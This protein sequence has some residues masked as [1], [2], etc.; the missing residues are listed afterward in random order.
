MNKTLHGPGLLIK[1]SGINIVA[2]NALPLS[3]AGSSIIMMAYICKMGMFSSCWESKTICKVS[4]STKDIKLKNECSEHKCLICDYLSS[5][6]FALYGHN[7]LDLTMDVPFLITI[8][9]SVRCCRLQL[10]SLTT[11]D[12]MA[13]MEWNFT[14]VCSAKWEQMFNFPS[15]FSKSS[16]DI[17]SVLA[18]LWILMAFWA[19]FQNKYRL[20]RYKDFHYKD[21]AV[22]L[23]L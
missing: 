20:S 5:W 12:Q 4:T 22:V 14:N 19:L 1:L 8:R 9:D 13:F 21:K 16:S 17:A 6:I 23:S 10:F 11:S 3:V 7:Y 18:C 15:T 2:I